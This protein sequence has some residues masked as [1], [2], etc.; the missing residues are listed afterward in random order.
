[1]LLALIAKHNVLI[2]SSYELRAGEIVH[3][4][5]TQLE[6]ERTDFG[7][8]FEGGLHVAGEF[9][10]SIGYPGALAFFAEALN[11]DA[12]GQQALR[13]IEQSLPC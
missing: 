6:R 4:I 2:E 8:A 11:D 12:Q 9:A 7:V 10:V 3:T 1:M 13:M 5:A